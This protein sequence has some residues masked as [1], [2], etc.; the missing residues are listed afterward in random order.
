MG[1]GRGGVSWGVRGHIPLNLLL[2]FWWEEPIVIVGFIIIM[3]VP[4][5]PLVSTI[6]F[7][8]I[9]TSVYF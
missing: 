3:L 2:F 9:E 5:E 1:G 7:C 4:W 8:Y 6:E